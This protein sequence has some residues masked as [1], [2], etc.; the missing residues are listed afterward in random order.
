M[1]RKV[2]LPL[3]QRMSD[4]IQKPTAT[5]MR[6]RLGGRV[7]S[8]PL[9]EV[10]GA[11]VPLGGYV[12]ITSRVGVLLAVSGDAVDV[13]VERGTVKRTLAS[14]VRAHRGAAPAEL[15]S[16]SESVVV[17]A[18]LSEGQRVSVERSSGEVATGTLIEK[19]RYGA[20]VELDD[21]TLL[22]VGFRKV[23]PSTTEASTP[24]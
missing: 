7:T 21:R 11:S 22:A 2:F 14:E 19:C 15:G 16:V 13:Y 5:V 12:V 3:T 6:E 4:S 23:W 18:R 24:S 10:E 17:F 8:E 1:A 9:L 20:I